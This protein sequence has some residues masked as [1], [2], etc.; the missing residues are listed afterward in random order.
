MD[1]I[2]LKIKSFTNAETSRK[3]E[4][5]SPRLASAGVLPL[6]PDTGRVLLNLRS[7]KVSSHKGEWS[8]WGGGLEDNETPEEAAIRELA[9]EAGYS[10]PIRLVRAYRFISPDKVFSY[11]HFL[12]IVK[13]EFRP[14]INWE[15]DAWRWIKPADFE[16]LDSP[17]H[18]GFLEFIEN[19]KGLIELYTGAPAR[20]P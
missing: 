9:E 13:E 8:V 2:T 7:Q 5:G 16:I 19:S 3:T 1:K 18:P 6:C 20:L 11:H 4:G 10:G 12:G 17:M 15:S 14:A